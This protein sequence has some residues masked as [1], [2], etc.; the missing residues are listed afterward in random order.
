MECEKYEPKS[1]GHERVLCQHLQ[2]GSR[3]REEQ[4]GGQVGACLGARDEEHEEM[5]LEGQECQTV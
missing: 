4:C 5:V 1:A 2:G 3:Q